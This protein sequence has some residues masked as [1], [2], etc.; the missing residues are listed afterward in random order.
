MLAGEL[1][2]PI[3]R[4]NDTKIG[5]P[6]FPLAIK[7]IKAVTSSLASSSQC[8]IRTLKKYSKEVSAFFEFFLK[9]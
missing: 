1:G 4:E 5:T 7:F 3:F 6:N 2:I 9:S 8:L